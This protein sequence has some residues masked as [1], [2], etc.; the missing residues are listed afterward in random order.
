MRRSLAPMLAA[1]VLSL[2]AAA[3]AADAAESKMEIVDASGQPEV[4]AGA[5]PAALIDE[6]H[7]DESSP[8]GESIKGFQ[9]DL[10]VGMGGNPKAVPLCPRSVASG[11][12]YNGEE[13]EPESQ[14][15]TALIESEGPATP[16][17]IYAMEPAPNEL[18]VFFMEDR[19]GI[20]LVAS[21]SPFDQRLRLRAEDLPQEEG[22]VF[23][24][25]R[26]ELWGVPA[27]KQSETSIPRVPLLTMPTRCDLGPPTS[28]F[29]VWTWQQP[30]RETSDSLDTGQPVRD[31]ASLAFA[32]RTALSLDNPV[33]DA[34]SGAR[35]EL[36]FPQNEDPDGRAAA[37]ARSVTFTM[38]AGT[39]LSPGGA[40]GLVPCGDAELGAGSKEEA[41]CPAAS[42][43]GSVQ[44]AAP[45]LARPLSGSVY[46]GEERPEERFRI[47][48]VV[49]GAGMEV[50]SGGALRLDPVTGRVSTVLE[51]LPQFAFDRMTLSFD[52]GPGAL[53]STPPACG[54]A[55]ATATHTP[56][57][58]TAPVSWE[59]Q[60]AVSA[61]GGG[62]CLGPPSFAPGFTAGATATAAGKATTFA[63]TVRRRDGEQL[64]E[65]LEFSL[66]AG[67][68]ARLGQVE[69]CAA[70]A[71][72]AGA[73][74]E[75]SL[76]GH[77]VAEVGPGSQPARLNGTMHLTDPYR[78]S[79]F[80]L[81][82]VFPAKIGPFDLGKLIV[83]GVLRVD[84][85][86]GRFT[87]VTDA[88]PR[89]VE[90]ISVRFQTIGLD[91]DRPGLLR[92][93]TSCEQSSVVATV[94]SF[95]GAV[96]RS[97]TPFRARDCIDLPFRPAFTVALTGA[98]AMVEDDRPGLRISTRLRAGDANLRAADIALP[99][100]LKQDPAGLRGICARAEAPD[101]NCPA[102][103]RIGTASARTPMLGEPLR[104]WVHLVQPRGNGDP[105]VW[106]SLSGGGIEVNMKSEAVRRDGRLHTL[107]AGLPDL[108]ISRLTQRFWGGKRGI[109]KLAAGLCRDGKPRRLQAAVQSEGQNRAERQARVAVGVPGG[110]RG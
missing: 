41:R 107:L 8:S 108:P 9:I 98:K 105:D 29:R 25:V 80:G 83:R 20:K 19:V 76:I 99:A 59:G 100:L 67:V 72:A 38:P 13:C 45:S 40:V 39:S 17:P 35:V 106:I 63:T 53:L 70:A 77:T 28:V 75:A 1:L 90:G 24:R 2:L 66:P 42:R 68:S 93:P 101:G 94:R 79:P 104:G 56:Y 14:V 55:P 96:S 92:N 33:A 65:R 44:I 30:D 52:G 103:S 48:V 89:L 34:P 37:Q 87:V 46:L 26:I 60:V 15:G 12:G 4:R 71:A 3:P 74:P 31:C 57:S 73:C 69:R 27:E 36:T 10:P 97:E 7:V 110:C 51:G 49:R 86:S 11:S 47:F 5:H 81:A 102:S 64:P 23:K 54:R 84:P 109:F 62:P 82:L 88:L 78:R 43:I 58:G 91:L 16:T 6:I 61:P 22:G 18:A 95:D 21:L 32:P 50:K 85:V